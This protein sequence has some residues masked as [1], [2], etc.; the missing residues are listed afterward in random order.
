MVIMSTMLMPIS[1]W[2]CG[3]DHRDLVFLS[4]PKSDT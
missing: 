1:F 3:V 2:G 4:V